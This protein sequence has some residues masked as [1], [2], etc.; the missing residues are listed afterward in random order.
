M[1]TSS[2]ADGAGGSVDLA[3][4]GALAIAYKSTLFADSKPGC[5]RAVSATCDEPAN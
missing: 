4:L 5:A 1:A 3:N 2:R